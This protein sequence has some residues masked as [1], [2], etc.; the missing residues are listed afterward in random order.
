MAIENSLIVLLSGALVGWLADTWMKRS[1][2]S[3]FG[4]IIVGIVGG[5]IAGYLSGLFEMS[6]KGT[7]GS[8]MTAMVGAIV[9]LYLIELFSR[10]KDLATRRD[11]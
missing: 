6:I 11:M 5:M 9:L 3:L 1:G 8:M 4:N 7:I 10:T 2:L